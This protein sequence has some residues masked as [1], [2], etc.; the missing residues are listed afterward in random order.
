MSNSFDRIE[1][2]MSQEAESRTYLAELLKAEA[3]DSELARQNAEEELHSVRTALTKSTADAQRLERDLLSTKEKL[4]AQKALADELSESHT[5]AQT[6]R[7]KEIANLKKEKMGLKRD[8]SELQSELEKVRSEQQQKR[9]YPRS[10]SNSIVVGD[11]SLDGLEEEVG[12]GDEAELGGKGNKRRTTLGGR[13]GEPTSPGADAFAD[14]V[15]SPLGARGPMLGSRDAELSELRSRL[16]MAQRKSGKDSADKRKQ[17]EQ[18][19]HLKALLAKAGVS[20]GQAELVSDVESSDEDEDDQGQHAEWIDDQSGSPR[21]LSKR[22]S[23]APKKTSLVNR[24]GFGGAAAATAAARR[25]KSMVE[26]GEE[27]FVDAESAGH[28]SASF[29]DFD[30]AFA[31]A[32]RPRVSEATVRPGAGD[33][34]HDDNSLLPDMP[35]RRPRGRK[36]N[37]NLEAI[38]AAEAAA[39]ASAGGVALGAELG[40][41]AMAEPPRE[42][43]EASMMTEPLPDLLEPALAQRDEEHAR[44]LAGVLAEMDKK[45]TSAVDKAVTSRDSEHLSLLTSSLDKK[46]NI[47]LRSLHSALNIWPPFRSDRQR[48][49]LRWQSARGLIPR[50]CPMHLPKSSRATKRHWPTRACATPTSSP[51]RWPRAAR[52]SQRPKQHIAR[53]CPMPKSSTPRSCRR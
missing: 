24:L 27:E 19:S 1:N 22:R 5:A 15:A 38:Q 36:S 49:M 23:V 31:V 35:V 34:S 43:A 3:Y 21:P 9:F 50:H 8:H 33:V 16:G 26:S 11:R 32:A 44:A 29:H 30:P 28:S 45:H 10:V 52:H 18:I 48:T 47:A 40:D 39:A 7:D 41:V 53:S 20:L 42:M 4:E 6:R 14:A 17:R 25:P 46:R 51:S 13:G 2:A 37:N 12:D